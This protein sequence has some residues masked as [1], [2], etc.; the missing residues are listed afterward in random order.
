MPRARWLAVVLLAASQPACNLDSCNIG[1]CIDQVALDATLAV[2]YTALE[3]ASAELCRNGV[4]GVGTLGSA[5]TDV[6]AQLPS[7]TFTGEVSASANASGETQVV[8][9]YYTGGTAGGDPPFRDGDVYH[10]LLA[11]AD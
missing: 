5:S 2:D 7:T 1:S 8:F 6:Y 9:T 4:C 3:S 10:V 11:E